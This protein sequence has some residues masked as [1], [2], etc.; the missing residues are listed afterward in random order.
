MYRTSEYSRGR[1]RKTEVDVVGTDIRWVYHDP[2]TRT[3]GDWTGEDGLS[4]GRESTTTTA[5]GGS[6]GLRS[7]DGV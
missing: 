5:R 1:R 4:P 6:H 2:R 7:R 3:L